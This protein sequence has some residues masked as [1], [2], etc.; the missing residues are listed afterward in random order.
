[1]LELGPYEPIDLLCHLHDINTWIDESE[2][3]DPDYA[4]QKMLE[5]LEAHDGILIPQWWQGNNQEFLIEFNENYA[6]NHRAKSFADKPWTPEER[7]LEMLETVL[8]LWRRERD[9]KL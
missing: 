4:I 3:D 9:K 1:M 2:F 8:E 5:Q 6:P 7:Q